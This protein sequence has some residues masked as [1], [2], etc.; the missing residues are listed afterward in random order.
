MTPECE[1]CGA[2]LD[3]HDDERCQRMQE[4][5]RAEEQEREAAEL[6]ERV[7]KLEETVAE[8]K[9][10]VEHQAPADAYTVVLPVQAI[11]GNGAVKLELC[12]PDPRFP[13]QQVTTLHLPPSVVRGLV[14]GDW[15]RMTVT[16]ERVLGPSGETG[17][18]PQGDTET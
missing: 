15:V 14:S 5:E 1:Y 7:E 9:R 3:H 11:T 2:K 10:E 12:R 6:S 17:P 13:E 4:Q 18:R 16:L 8:L